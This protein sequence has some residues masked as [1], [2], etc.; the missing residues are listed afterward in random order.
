MSYL[1]DTHAF[2]WYVDGKSN[3]PLKVKEIIQNPDFKKFVSIASLW[4]IAIK[5]SKDKLILTRPFET[6]PEYMKVNEFI[7]LPIKAEHLF[8]IKEL[9]HHHGD[10]FDRLLIAQAITE[11]MTII[12]ADQQFKAYPVNVIW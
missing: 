11:N 10:P 2:L 5:T 1:L 7:S 12:S 4:E 3:L 8:Q 6:L 9:P